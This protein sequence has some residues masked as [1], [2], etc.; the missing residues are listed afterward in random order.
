MNGFE[1]VFVAFYDLLVALVLLAERG[2]AA[3]RDLMLRD[4][5]SSSAQG[6]ILISADL[7][8]FCIFAYT[9]RGWFRAIT[10]FVTIMILIHLLQLWA[11]V[12][13]AAAWY[14]PTQSIFPRQA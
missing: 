3:M 1:Q 13:G 4:G 11:A 5:I 10:V 2:E 9:C 12:P 8:M 14:R 6:I 7:V